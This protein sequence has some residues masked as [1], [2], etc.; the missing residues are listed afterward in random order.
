MSTSA[1]EK[2]ADGRVVA[3]VAAL[4]AA[5]LVA[6][7]WARAHNRALV[8]LARRARR[9]IRGSASVVADVELG[10]LLQD[11][12]RV[13][14]AADRE[15]SRIT[16]AALHGAY[17]GSGGPD[18]EAAARVH[19]ETR[20]HMAIAK[21]ATLDS[22]TGMWRRIIDETKPAVGSSQDEQAR[23]LTE[24][25]DRAAAEGLTSFTDKAGR[26]WSPDTYAAL[27]HRTAV[28]EATMQ[29]AV[30]G[31]EHG[32]VVV[33]AV[34]DACPSCRQFEGTLLAVTTD[35][36]ASR[37]GMWRVTGTVGQARLAGLGHPGC[38]HTLTPWTPDMTRP[39]RVV[40]Q[41]PTAYAHSQRTRALERRVR[42]WQ[43]RVSVTNETGTPQQK[44]ATANRLATARADLSNHTAPPWRRRAAS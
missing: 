11:V 27:A 1:P 42:G 2:D 8:A 4:A 36:L 15:A 16:A 30:D 12:S 41:D 38:R 13:W 34:G 29:A 5:M 10:D 39:P 3:V 21:A 17:T 7:V 23:A 6:D 31:A 44:A 9:V 37:P 33:S 35:G 26:R 28:S 25:L 43:R 22:T 14:D 40:R 18:P 19:A 32:Y 24:A 20:R